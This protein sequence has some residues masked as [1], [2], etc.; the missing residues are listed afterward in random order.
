MRGEALD[1]KRGPIDEGGLLNE[2]SKHLRRKLQ[3]GES[4][5]P[6]VGGCIPAY[7]TR[8]MYLYSILSGAWLSAGA[9]CIGRSRNVRPFLQ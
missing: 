7:R 9:V 1:T 3:S 6:R 2:H 8:I 4:A 5:G